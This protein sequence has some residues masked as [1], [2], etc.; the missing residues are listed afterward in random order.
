MNIVNE[1]MEQDAPT[2]VMRVLD[3]FDAL[4]G[5]NASGQH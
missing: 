1:D 3:F 2:V 5:R 4:P